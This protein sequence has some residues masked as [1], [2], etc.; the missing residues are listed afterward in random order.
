MQLTDAIGAL[1]LNEVL[2]T[3][4][5]L[6]RGIRYPTYL[7]LDEFQNFV[8]PDME[9][10]LP[11]VRQLGL[12]LFLSHQSFSQLKRGD[13]DLTP[14][15][16][17]AQS[18]L[19]FGLQGEDADLLAHELA[20]ITYD[21]KRIKDEIYSRRQLVTG[22]SIV[23]LSTWSD[24]E[25]E[26]R[27]W[28]RDYGES[29]SQ[30]ENVSRSP[31]RQVV[32]GEGRDHGASN[33]QGESGGKTTTHTRG[34][35]QVLKPEYE[36]FL[37]LS[38]RTYVTFEEQRNLWA[39]AARNLT[40]GSGVLRLVDDPAIHEVRVKRSAPGHLA[41]D[42]NIFARE[43]PEA[44]EEVDR[45]VETNFRSEF[46]SRPEVIDHEA[47]ERLQSVLQPRLTLESGT[48]LTTA[49]QQPLSIPKTDPF[50]S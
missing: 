26:A 12:R 41:W 39:K 42:A 8:G 25:A 30:N 27:Q 14:M 31:D 47:D 2:A 38:S 46:F 19:A 15:I 36:R 50:I 11:E 18:R 49:K 43:F 32:R 33:R 22:Q 48:R 24:A 21:P 40:T 29:H 28:S 20:S 17:Q 45:L 6:P 44:L 13:Y 16:F 1:V 23:E 4:R 34:T 7:V 37:E 10:A 35:H 3:A 5:S 9:A